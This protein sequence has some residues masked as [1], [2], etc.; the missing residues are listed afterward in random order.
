MADDKSNLNSENKENKKGLKD[1]IYIKNILGI[2]I[3]LLALII[4]SSIFLKVI[5]HHGNKIEVPDFT[6]MTMS[7][8]KYNAGINNIKVIVI[9]SV[10]VRRMKKGA[11]YSQNPKPGSTVKKGRRIRLT[12]NSITPKKI[13]MPN[14]VGV[15]MRQAH[16]ELLSRGLNLGQLI[17]VNDIATNNVIRQLYNKKEIKPGMYINS[18]S[19][20]DLV[21]GLN[22]FDNTTNVPDVIGM[23]YMRAVSAVHDYSLNVSRLVFDSSVRNYADSLDAVVYKQGPVASEIPV[24]MGSDVSLYLTV[25]A[26]KI[27]NATK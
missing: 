19:N 8:A 20:I 21:V 13:I 4:S 17:Y 18:G 5:T 25:D 1:N 16:A 2:F 10:Y 12:I 23:K 9:D 27:P 24:I 14:L 22:N 26:A 3:A 15:S 6:N 7:E 11:V